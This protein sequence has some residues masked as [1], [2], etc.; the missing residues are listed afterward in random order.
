MKRL[1]LAPLFLGLL[2]S[3]YAL[4][5][6][7]DPKKKLIQQQQEQYISNCN[8]GNWNNA[9]SKVFEIN[10]NRIKIIFKTIGAAAAAANLL[11]VLSIP[12]NKDDKLTNNKNGNVILVNSTAKLNFSESS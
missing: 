9:C 10:R 6:R 3:N 1:I 4:A 2:I 8:Q 7:P 12:A 5:G 11:L